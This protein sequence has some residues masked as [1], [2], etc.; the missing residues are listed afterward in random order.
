L[1]KKRII[2]PITIS[3]ILVTVLITYARQKSNSICPK[4]FPECYLQI[5]N[6][7]DLSISR[8]FG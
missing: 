7:A 4:L 6:P 1:V 3:E 8:V 2:I 5:K